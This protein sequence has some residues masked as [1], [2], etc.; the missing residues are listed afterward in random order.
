[1]HVLAWVDSANNLNR[2]LSRQSLNEFEQRIL[3]AM[4]ASDSSQLIE[5]P[6]A[7]RLGPHRALLYREETGTTTKF[8]PYGPPAEEWLQQVRAQL[9]AA[10]VVESVQDLDGF[11]VS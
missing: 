5:S 7:A 1:M 9:T 4:N 11:Q 8:R 3:F 2:W 6:A 10:E